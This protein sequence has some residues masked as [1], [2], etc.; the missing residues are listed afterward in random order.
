MKKNS[1]YD[2]LAQN[3]STFLSSYDVPAPNVALVD[4]IL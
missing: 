2:T 1:I 4:G 3:I